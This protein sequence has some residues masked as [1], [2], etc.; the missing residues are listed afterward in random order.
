MGS[1]RRQNL[2]QWP[3]AFRK[4]AVVDEQ[5]EVAV[6]DEQAVVTEPLNQISKDNR[7]PFD[8]N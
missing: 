4:A 6:V 8:D 5:Q 3:N 1:S 2:R 7:P